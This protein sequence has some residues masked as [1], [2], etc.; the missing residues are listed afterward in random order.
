MLLSRRSASP[1]VRLRAGTK[2]DYYGDEA[3]DWTAPVRAALPRAQIQEVSSVEEDG[4]ARRLLVDERVFFQPG[5]ADLTADDRLE[6]NGV[7]WTIEGRPIVRTGL[8]SGVYTT[9]ALR[10]LD[11]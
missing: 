5:R 4:V 11:G 3:E 6:E 8:A 9:A 10:R 1:V 7:V 2:T